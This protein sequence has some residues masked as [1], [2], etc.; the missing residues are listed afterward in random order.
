L[1]GDSPVSAED[2]LSRPQPPPDERLAYGADPNQFLEVRIPRAKGP[3]AVL[4]NIHGGYWR[5]KYDLGH[6]GQLC[7][8]C[9]WRDSPPSTSSTGVLATPAADA[10]NVRRHPRGLSI[11]SP[12]AVAFQS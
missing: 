8:A 11:Y 12:A 2:I 10:G 1:L 5:A 6:A 7:E 3:H 9:A 4:L